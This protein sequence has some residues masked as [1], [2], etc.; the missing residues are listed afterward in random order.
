MVPVF[1]TTDNSKYRVHSSIDSWCPRNFLPLLYVTDL[2]NLSS[3][4]HKTQLQTVR[5][6]RVLSFLWRPVFC[7][8]VQVL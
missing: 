1:F 8:A 6:F 5:G 2:T 7:E 4:D 3:S